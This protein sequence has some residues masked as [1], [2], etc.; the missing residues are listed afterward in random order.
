MHVQSAWFRLGFI[1]HAS[2]THTIQTKCYKYKLF[3]KGNYACTRHENVMF[4]AAQSH[5]AIR[6]SLSIGKCNTVSD[7][8]KLFVYH[9]SHWLSNKL[10]NATK[11]PKSTNK[12]RS[13]RKKNSNSFSFNTLM[14][15]TT[16]LQRFRDTKRQK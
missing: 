2:S 1:M 15:S 9:P 6:V 5:S 4:N 10:K 16:S 14:H 11:T 8:V 13:E 3:Q 7:S 12:I